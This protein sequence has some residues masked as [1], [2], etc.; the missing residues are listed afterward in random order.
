MGLLE[1]PFSHTPLWLPSHRLNLIVQPPSDVEAISPNV[2]VFGDR[3]CKEL[4]VWS[5]SLV[6]ALCDPM[7]C[8]TPGFLVLHYLPE[9]AQTYV[10]GS[11]WS[12]PLSPPS[13][14]ALNLPSIR[15]F[16]SSGQSLGLQH[17]SFMNVQ[18]WFPLGL[19][20]L[21]SLLSNGLSSLLQHHSSKTSIQHSAF[22]TV[23]LT[24]IHDYWKNHSLD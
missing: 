1:I 13:P 9:F 7:D 3:T 19:T 8:S 12:H 5:L 20:S 17:Q 6:R 18:D 23:Q 4:L 21:I 22:F 15:V 2:T 16:T 14:P 24:S 11:L 10:I